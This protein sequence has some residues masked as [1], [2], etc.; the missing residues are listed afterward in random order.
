M[1]MRLDKYL[2]EGAF[3]SRTKAARAIERGLVLLNGKTAKPSDEVKPSDVVTVLE[4]KENYV[5]EGGFKLAKAFSEFGSDVRGKVFADIGASTGGF[6]DVLLRN[7]AR[8]VFA[9]DVG[10][11]QLDEKLAADPRVAVMDGVN[12][13]GLQKNSFSEAL[14]GIVTDISFISLTY[15][16]PVFSE[17]LGEGGCVYA[18]VKPQF[19]CGPAALDKH[20]IVKD[21]KRRRAAIGKIY[22]CA[23]SCG[24]APLQICTAPEHERKNK[25]FVMFL[26]KGAT[27]CEKEKILSI[28]K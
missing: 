6:T 18:L 12:A 8:H 14:D 28:E 27:P 7:G 4:S 10:E 2:S 21:A 9:V 17:I 5:S 13:R 1:I 19:E 22:D 25:E 16:L 3:S 20:G 24:L 11:C 26:Q 23:L 15:V